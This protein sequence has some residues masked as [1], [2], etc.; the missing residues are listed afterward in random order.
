MV[1]RA[2]RWTKLGKLSKALTHEWQSAA[3]ISNKCRYTTSREVARTLTSFVKLGIVEKRTQRVSSV[4][5]GMVTLYRLTEGGEE[6]L[7]HIIND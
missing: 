6:K 7:E 3:V 1:R 5:D 2:A 4:T